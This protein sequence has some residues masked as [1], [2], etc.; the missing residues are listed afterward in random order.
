MCEMNSFTGGYVHKSVGDQCWFCLLRIEGHCNGESK[1]GNPVHL[2]HF[3]RSYFS[4]SAE[5]L[6]TTGTSLP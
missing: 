5:F 2:E 4:S 3:E 1:K 6:A